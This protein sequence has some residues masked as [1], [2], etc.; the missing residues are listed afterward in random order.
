MTSLIN[1]NNIDTS[2]P[3]A[4]QDNSTQGFRT[5]FTNIR[6]NF[7][8]AE[9]EINALQNN[10]VLKQALTG[11][12]PDNNMNDVLIYAA[13]MQDIAFTKIT[14]S[15]A[16]GNIILNFASGQYY[17]LVTD[18]ATSLTFSNWPAAGESAVGYM[19]LQVQVTNVAHTVTIAANNSEGGAAL[20]NATDVTGYVAANAYSGTIT[21]PATGYYDFEFS[22]YDGGTEI[23]VNQLDHAPLNA[24]SEDLA[25]SAAVSLGVSTS[26]FSTAAAETATLAAGVNGQVKVLALYADMD[27][28]SL[29]NMVITVT[30]AGWKTSGTGTIT[31][32]A[33]G[34]AC[35]L[36]YVVGASV[37][38][39]SIVSGS[40]Y[41]ITSVGTTDFTELGAA[42]NTYGLQFTASS[43]GNVNSG[44]GYVSTLSK[45]FCIG[46]NGCVFA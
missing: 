28:S 18:G 37:P 13:R 17:S 29:D 25:A 5:N 39:T 45:W 40:T 8:Y 14:D 22:C 30:N 46:N 35:T 44:T 21:F 42:S 26:Y 16:A 24:S 43:N 19:R 36:K 27:D 41:Y 10:V 7:Q 12:A 2:Y 9:T 15:S 34:D 31:F 4:G 3:V 6:Q 20:I 38:A 11:G 23:M 1:P 32:A 33:V